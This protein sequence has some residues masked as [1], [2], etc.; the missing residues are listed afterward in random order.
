MSSRS[1]RR[2]TVSRGTVVTCPRIF[3]SDALAETLREQ[4]GFD[5]VVELSALEAR[6]EAAP[7]EQVTICYR[8]AADFVALRSAEGATPSAALGEWMVVARR[9]ERLVSAHGF[10]IK[11]LDLGLLGSAGSVYAAYL[12]MPAEA[13]TAC[14]PTM[15]LDPMERRLAGMYVAE[16][17]DSAALEAALDSSVVRLVNEAAGRGADAGAVMARY[18]ELLAA[19]ERLEQAET[20]IRRLRTRVES[21]EEVARNE[22]EHAQ[23]MNEAIQRELESCHR[24]QRALELRLMSLEQDRDTAEQRAHDISVRAEQAEVYANELHSWREELRRSI[25]YRLIAPLRRLRGSFK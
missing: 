24:Q 23:E 13:L 6:L 2:G 20:Q 5:E 3:V 15:N 14:A 8:T 11:L 21:V 22:R 1:R 18:R 10:L 16:S 9:I 25:S 12:D 17:T 4:G 7:V 19:E